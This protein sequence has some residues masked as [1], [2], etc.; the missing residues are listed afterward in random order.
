M[1]RSATPSGRKTRA[2]GRISARPALQAELDDMIASWT[3]RHTVAEVD[4]LMVEAA[5]PAGRI[6]RPADI[7]A[8]PH[9]QA[10]NAIHWEEHPA[11]GRVPMQ[12]VFPKFSETQG[13]IRRP[14]P[15]QVGPTRARCAL[16]EISG[17]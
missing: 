3:R 9:V 2:T 5:V 13:A 8:D 15:D 17:F 14:A 16:H 4:R 11:L 1:K 12:N 6:N 7:L 10:R